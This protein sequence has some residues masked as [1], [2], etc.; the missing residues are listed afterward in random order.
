MRI[1]KKFCWIIATKRKVKFGVVEG[2]GVPNKF[3]VMDLKVFR[4][5]KCQ[6]SL[7]WNSM[8]SKVGVNLRMSSI[9]PLSLKAELDRLT[10][11]LKS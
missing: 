5:L 1:H 6:H 3:V 11:F 2:F 8:Q 4:A 10:K 7:K 9:R